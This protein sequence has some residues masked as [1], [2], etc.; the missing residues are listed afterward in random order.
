[1]S[2]Q[3]DVE[4]LKAGME[5]ASQ[6]KHTAAF[7]RLGMES[8]PVPHTCPGMEIDTDQFHE[9]IVRH[10]AVSI[11]H[12][13]GT[14]KM[15]T[16][17]M[18]A[19]V[20]PENLKVHGVRGLRV[21]DASVMPAVVGGNTNAATIMIGERAADMIMKDWPKPTSKTSSDNSKTEL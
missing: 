16:D 8:L 18:T 17:P 9:C 3:E 20:H 7:K 12:L 2:R 6:L 4:V 10:N 13:V 5:W 15:G 21:A 19:V 1:M 11:W 14:C